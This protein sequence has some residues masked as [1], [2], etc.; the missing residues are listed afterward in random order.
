MSRPLRIEFP[1]AVYHLTAKGNFGQS[2][3]NDKTDAIH[4]LEFLGKEIF[5]Q[6]WICHAYCLLENHFHLIIETPEP[7]LSRGMGR[8]NMRYSQWFG[9]RH[10]CNGHLFHGRFKSI[11][12]Q[13][14]KFLLPLCRYVVLNPVRLKLVDHV[15]QWRWSSYRFLAYE[16][17][18]NEWL[19]LDWI[20]AQF[21]TT[22]SEKNNAWQNYVL[23]GI[24]LP[25]PWK[26][27]RSGY[28]LGDEKFLKRIAG[29]IKGKSLYQISKNAANPERPNLDQILEAVS[30]ASGVSAK[31]ILN[32]KVAPNEF[33]VTI[34]LLR[35]L[36]NLPLREVANL[37][38]ISQGRIS[39]IQK[40]IEDAGG[41]GKIFH[42]ARKLEN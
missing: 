39:Q 1:G 42:W 11:I 13:K 25:S 5:Q 23:K 28:Y 35:R 12:L 20:Q 19:T 27:L 10:K 32:K 24:N 22:K 2:I 40:R 6:R 3:F 41:L 15:N 30:E 21:E 7:N 29:E 17:E 36:A 38:K 9:R 8:L 4:F 16:K 34:Y 26:D 14:E 31:Q 37:T 18:K 33:Q